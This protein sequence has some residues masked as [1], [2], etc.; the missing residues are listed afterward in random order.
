MLA[1]LDLALLTIFV[2]C[3]VQ[4]LRPGKKNEPTLLP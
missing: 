4:L 3:S 2:L 1:S